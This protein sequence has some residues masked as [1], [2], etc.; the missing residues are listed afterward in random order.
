[1]SERVQIRKVDFED[2]QAPVTAPAPYSC[3]FI[4]TGSTILDLSI[5]GGWA[6]GRIFNLVGDRSTGKTLLAI[7][8]FAN[9]TRL[10]G[11]K[12]RMRYGETEAAFDTEYAEQ[13]GF[14][15]SVT[16]PPIPLA[17][18]ED[19]YKDLD[20]FSMKPG[21]SL[22]VLDSLDALSDEAE[23][24]REL[25]EGTFGATKPKKL[26]ELFRRLNKQ[27]GANNC[28]VG[29]ISQVRDNIGV[30][31][32]E[33]HTR[34]GGKALDFYS[35]QIVWLSQTGKLEREIRGQKRAYGID[36]KSKCKKCK[37]GNPFREAEFPIIFGYGVDDEQS[38]IDWLTKIKAFS[39]E[40]GDA[41]KKE[42]D[43]IKK[44]G[45]R[46]A[47]S[48]VRDFLVVRTKLEW[49]MFEEALA[50]KMRKY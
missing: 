21:P 24:K 34:S 45:D 38:M 27:L 32:G 5:G 18:V 43:K 6:S 7:E 1:M 37:V 12:A 22:Y 26:S 19:W 31:F 49:E 13:L 39:K 14:P 4:P 29:I 48:K 23:L 42:L 44:A 2:K 17:T 50:P 33:K 8:C 35:S 11:P 25:N 47:L 28:T 30:M 36:V 16:K 15:Q 46:D 9:F 20:E 10:F 41:A 40:E 3:D